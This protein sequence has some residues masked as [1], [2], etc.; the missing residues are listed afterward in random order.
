MFK[1]VPDISDP[2]IVYKKVNLTN[3]R[4]LEL[5]IEKTQERIIIKNT[6]DLSDFGVRIYLRL[7][8]ISYIILKYF[9]WIWI[10]IL[11]TYPDTRD[12]DTI[13]ILYCLYFDE[14]SKNRFFHAMYKIGDIPL[15]LTNMKKKFI[16]HNQAAS[17]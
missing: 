10:F 16:K 12:F 6:I 13:N 3:E 1:M 4:T 11:Q 2:N 17:S 5:R 7:K 8:M 15:L 9:S 14:F